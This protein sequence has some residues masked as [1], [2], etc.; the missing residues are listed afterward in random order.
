MCLKNIVYERF[1]WRRTWTDAWWK[2]RFKAAYSRLRSLVFKHPAA[3]R[4]NSKIN[5]WTKNYKVVGQYAQP[6]HTNSKKVY[7]RVNRTF[8]LSFTNTITVLIILRNPSRITTNC[9]DST[10]FSTGPT[11][12]ESPM[13]R[14]GSVYLTCFWLENKVITFPPVTWRRSTNLTYD[15]V[16]EMHK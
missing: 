14:C 11:S 12:Y 15:I 10:L 9:W 1:L 3:P 8:G 2:W 5:S 4:Q 7:Y 6:L 13:L 16:N